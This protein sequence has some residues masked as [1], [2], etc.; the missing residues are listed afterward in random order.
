MVSL[1][2]SCDWLCREGESLPCFG[3]ACCAVHG[4]EDSSAPLPILPL[5]VSLTVSQDGGPSVRRS[6]HWGEVRWICRYRG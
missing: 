4:S 3:S 2:A 6:P 5:A 1:K